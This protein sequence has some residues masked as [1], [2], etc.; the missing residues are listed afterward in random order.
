MLDRNGRG[1]LLGVVLIALLLAP[2]S[3]AVELVRDGK[4]VAVIVMTPAAMD[5]EAPE[6]RGRRR[7]VQDPIADVKYAASE[8]VE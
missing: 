2:V 6:T 8:R 7:A 3:Q 1:R 4:A 5:W